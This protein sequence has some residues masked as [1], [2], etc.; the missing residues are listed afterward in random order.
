MLGPNIGT[1]GCRV[2][3]VVLKCVCLSTA[4]APLLLR[5]SRFPNTA[6]KATLLHQLHPLQAACNAAARCCLHVLRCDRSMH[7]CTCV[8]LPAQCM[9]RTERC[10]M[11]CAVFAITVV[12]LH[13]LDGDRVGVLVT[14][15]ANL[16]LIAPLHHI[17]LS[18]RH[19]A[20]LQPHTHNQM[21]L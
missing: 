4:P 13:A 12:H 7:N 14:G 15:H 2:S 8:G 5:T 20:H 16:Q 1:D 6:H 11:L 17:G 9:C 3:T 19:E 10:H 18:Q 21:R